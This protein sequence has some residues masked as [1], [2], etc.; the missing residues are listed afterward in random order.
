[1]G[2]IRL[3]LAIA[4]ASLTVPVVAREAPYPEETRFVPAEHGASACWGASFFDTGRQISTMD[5]AITFEDIPPGTSEEWPEG[6]QFFNYELDATLAD[7]TE[8]LAAGTCRGAEDGGI[9]CE[10]ECDG[11]GATIR[12]DADGKAMVDIGT[13]GFIR[14]RDCGA[15]RNGV[16]LEATA[17]DSVF[18]LEPL[19]AGQCEPV[20]RRDYLAGVD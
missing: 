2:M 10:V 9:V 3:V 17:D 11:G 18:E 7:G 13:Y 6:R 12:L 16:V 4:A 14:L 15:E 19:P 1:M 20:I 8:G 5:F